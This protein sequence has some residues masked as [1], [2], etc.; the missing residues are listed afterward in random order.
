MNSVNQVGNRSSLV[1]ACKADQ[2]NDGRKRLYIIDGDY[3]ILLG[4]RK[5]KLKYLYRLNAYDI[6]N[7]II[8]EHAIIALGAVSAPNEH[9]AEIRERLDFERWLAESCDLLVPLFI[10]YAAA[11]LLVPSI[12]TVAYPVQTL[13]EDTKYGLRF[14]RPK[15]RSQIRGLLK[16]IFRV[17]GRQRYLAVRSNAFDVSQR[18]VKD[19]HNLISGKRY[20]LPLVLFRVKRIC[21]YKGTLDQLSTLAASHYDTRME[22]RLART[23]RLLAMR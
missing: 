14:L 1:A 8:S 12:Q 11:N 21:G 2:I 13:C 20:L 6:E 22:Q 7:L 5:P 23:V 9:E 4:R 15:I 17:A 16:I 19:R 10:V 3:D 18:R